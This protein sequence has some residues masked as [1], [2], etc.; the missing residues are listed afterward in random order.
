VE[1]AIGLT[2][3]N[4]D[5]MAELDAQPL[6][7]LDVLQAAAELWHAT[8]GGP[9]KLAATYSRAE[10][11][12]IASKIVGDDAAAFPNKRVVAEHIHDALI[13]AEAGK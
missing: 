1:A 8:A 9:D 10:L 6:A 4:P 7:R 3:N 13:D 11:D 2:T 12:A 5:T